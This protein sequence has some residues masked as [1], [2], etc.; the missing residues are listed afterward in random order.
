MLKVLKVFSES[1]AG[2][3]GLEMNKSEGQ[4][5]F[6]VSKAEM[7]HVQRIGAIWV[8]LKNTK[9]P[10]EMYHWKVSHTDLQN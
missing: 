2:W 8:M 9:I 1:P 7:E 4:F 3:T 10:A 5:S 6:I